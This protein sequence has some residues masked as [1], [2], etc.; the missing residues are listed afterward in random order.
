M[1]A[2]TSVLE[3]NILLFYGQGRARRMDSDRIPVE[4]N[5]DATIY[6]ILI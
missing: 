4:L 3:K 1:P 2:H 6:Y 5:L